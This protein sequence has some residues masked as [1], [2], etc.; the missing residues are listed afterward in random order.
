VRD[1]ISD[2]RQTEIRWQILKAMLDDFP[3]LQERTKTY[4]F[5]KISLLQSGHPEGSS[6]KIKEL[7]QKAIKETRKGV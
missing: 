6:L 1:D 5:A 3:E 7:L 2:P 4:L